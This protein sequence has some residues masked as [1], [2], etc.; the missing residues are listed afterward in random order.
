M[1]K[2]KGNTWSHDGIVRKVD[3]DIAYLRKHE[4]R[5]SFDI[6][7]YQKIPVRDVVE[8]LLDHLHLEIKH[9]PEVTGLVDK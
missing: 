6:Q 4:L 2:R 3:A 1:F 7:G 9:T 8:M 5:I